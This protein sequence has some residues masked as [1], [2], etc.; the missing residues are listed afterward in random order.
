[1]KSQENKETKLTV[2]HGD[3]SACYGCLSIATCL[4]CN[5][6]GSQDKYT[7]LAVRKSRVEE[8]MLQFSQS[9]S[10]IEV[11]STNIPHIL[12]LLFASFVMIYIY[13]GYNSDVKL[14][15]W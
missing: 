9:F 6:Q 13:N 14:S 4:M 12:T 10:G 3:W 15:I 11:C 2:D 8:Q 1:M 7:E 5:W